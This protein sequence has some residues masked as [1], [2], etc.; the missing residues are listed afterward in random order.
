[1]RLQGEGE[2][3]LTGTARVERLAWADSV[4]KLCIYTMVVAVTSQLARGDLLDVPSF[5][6]MMVFVG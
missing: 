5:V 6:Q 4:E 2:T 3:L 1:M